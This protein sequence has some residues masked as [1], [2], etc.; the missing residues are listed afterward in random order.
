VLHGL[1][2][3]SLIVRHIEALQEFEVFFLETDAAMMLL[4]IWNV[5]NDCI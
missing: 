1:K 4:L 2:N 5:S 3:I